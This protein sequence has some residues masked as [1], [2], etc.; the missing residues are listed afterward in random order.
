[1]EETLLKYYTD[2]AGQQRVK[3][4]VLGATFM[5]YTQFLFLYPIQEKIASNWSYIPY[6][7]AVFFVGVVTIQLLLIIGIMHHLCSLTVFAAKRNKY[8][9][10]C[11]IRLRNA[12]GDSDNGLLRFLNSRSRGLKFLSDVSSSLAMSLMILIVIL[13]AFVTYHL[14]MRLIGTAPEFMWV[15]GVGSALFVGFVWFY[16]H[17]LIKRIRYANCMRYILC[18]TEE[19]NKEKIKKGLLL[20]NNTQPTDKWFEDWFGSSITYVGEHEMTNPRK[21]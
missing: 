8:E 21:A 4:T 14:G 17:E 7:N 13:T 11:I 9:A 19:M 5:G 1:M 6:G 12:G 15:V 16:A 18:G 2:L 20:F 3:L 10:R